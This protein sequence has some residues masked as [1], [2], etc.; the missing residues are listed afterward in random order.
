MAD[1]KKKKGSYTRPEGWSKTIKRSYWD[2]DKAY[3]GSTDE[4]EKEA[5]EK[6]A[7]EDAKKARKTKF[8]KLF[9]KLFDK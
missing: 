7:K 2:K 3:D 1:K 8:G 5:E 4:V 6:K 9:S